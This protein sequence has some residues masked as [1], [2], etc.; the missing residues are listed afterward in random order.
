MS[1]DVSEVGRVT[2]AV[3]VVDKFLSRHS[4]ELRVEARL[5]GEVGVVR[6]SSPGGAR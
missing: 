4:L 1:V 2:V 3:E 5:G 6:Q